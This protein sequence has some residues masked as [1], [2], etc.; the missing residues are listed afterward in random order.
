MSDTTIFGSA[1]ATATTSLASLLGAKTADGKDVKDLKDADSARF[2]ALLDAEL[3][4][5]SAKDDELPA[6]REGSTSDD[7]LARAFAAASVM[8]SPP[9]PLPMPEVAPA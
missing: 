7:A 2:G 8:P 4:A 6:S 5:T 9:A 1:T 3:D